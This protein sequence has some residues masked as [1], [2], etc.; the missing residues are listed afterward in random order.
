MIIK[1]SLT[2]KL[3]QRG[4]LNRRTGSV[5]EAYIDLNPLLKNPFSSGV[6]S[7]DGCT[8]VVAVVTPKWFITANV[9]DSRAVLIRAND[10][11]VIFQ[12]VDHDASVIERINHIVKFNG[13]LLKKIHTPQGIRLSYFTPSENEKVADDNI[14]YE[15][16]VF[17]DARIALPEEFKS[18]EILPP[19]YFKSTKTLNLTGVVGDITFKV[20]AKSFLELKRALNEIESYSNLDNVEFLNSMHPDKFK[21]VP[22]I[23]APIINSIP[24]IVF[25][26]LKASDVRYMMVIA[27]DGLW[28][29]MKDDVTELLEIISPHYPAVFSEIKN[30]INSLIQNH[31]I[32]LESVGLKRNALLAELEENPK[33]NKRLLV[34]LHKVL[35][36]LNSFVLSPPKLVAPIRDDFS[37]LVMDIHPVS[38]LNSVFDSN[39]S[40]P[41]IFAATRAGIG[42]SITEIEKSQ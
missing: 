18:E 31:K 3:I 9:G 7:D 5:S 1:H 29:Y 42:G 37:A 35:N 39:L 22:V 33:S 24:D 12:T 40:K 4:L 21:I 2:E 38:G 32:S 8:M 30:D 13:M 25:T 23:S 16:K 17:A 36:D 14:H 15:N 26:P 34:A 11:K 19:R 28:Q 27:S 10:Y 6:P 41:L 20:D